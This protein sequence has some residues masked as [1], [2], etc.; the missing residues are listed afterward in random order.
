MPE[1]KRTYMLGAG[2]LSYFLL[3]V[4]NVPCMV[5]VLVVACGYGLSCFL[6]VVCILSCIVAHCHVW[7]RYCPRTKQAARRGKAFLQHWLLPF[8]EVVDIYLENRSFEFTETFAV[9]KLLSFKVTSA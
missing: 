3:V 6:L 7:L 4:C 8:F 9:P 5:V 1:R 2:G